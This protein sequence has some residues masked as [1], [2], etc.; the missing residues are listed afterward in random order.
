M[1]VIIEDFNDTS[2]VVPINFGSSHWG[3]WTRLSSGGRTG[4]CLASPQ[5]MAWG[6]AATITCTV[7]L[8][9]GCTSVRF[10]YRVSTEIWDEFQFYIG[11]RST[12]ALTESGEVPWTQSPAFNVTGVSNIRF[13]YAID[14]LDAGGQNRIWIDDIEFTI[15]DV[16]VIHGWGPVPAFRKG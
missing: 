3:G 4:G 11:N 10:W 13:V 12:P 1:A 9:Q 8:P 7:T 6:E 2:Y 5:P 16:N 14:E 15:P